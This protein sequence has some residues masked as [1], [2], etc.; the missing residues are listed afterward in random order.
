VF[1]SKKDQPEHCPEVYCEPLLIPPQVKFMEKV[2]KDKNKS[3]LV[4][5]QQI[6]KERARKHS[7]D[8]DMHD[9]IQANPK[10]D[11]VKNGWIT[12]RGT[13]RR[14]IDDK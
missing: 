10:E 12:D 5:Q 9:L 11:A 13:K 14:A 8:V 3:Q 2:D 7:R 1:K 6:L 4:G